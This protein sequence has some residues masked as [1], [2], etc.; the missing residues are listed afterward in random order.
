MQDLYKQAIADAKALRASAIANAKATLQETFAP[1][2]EAAVKR[3][4][5]E[6]LEED[7]EE[8]SDH[9]PIVRTGRPNNKLEKHDT[10]Y[11]QK[12]KKG[13]FQMD[14]DLEE[15]EELEESEEEM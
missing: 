9:E 6:E 2:V 7:L 14:E 12:S 10:P 4:L 15:N 1:Q 8:S 3:S 5:R 13:E 11:S